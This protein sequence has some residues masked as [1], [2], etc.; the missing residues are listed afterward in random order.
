MFG[1]APRQ[2]ARANYSGP[3]SSPPSRSRARRGLPR[4]SYCS[5]TCQELGV[6]RA[7]ESPLPVAAS[8]RPSFPPRRSGGSGG[9]RR[10]RWEE[11]GCG[12]CGRR[13]RCSAGSRAPRRPQGDPAWPRGREAKPGK[14][15]CTWRRTRSRAAVPGRPRGLRLPRSPLLLLPPLPSGVCCGAAPSPPGESGEG[16]ARARPT[17]LQL[18]PGLS[19]EERPPRPNCHLAVPPGHPGRIQDADT[20]TLAFARP[21]GLP[22]SPA[23]SSRPQL[24]LWICSAR[25]VTSGYSC[26]LRPPRCP[27]VFSV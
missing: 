27:F 8:P 4:P 25:V 22:L 24:G 15:S 11:T 7:T 12:D 9:E 17:A 3:G 19:L 10:R 18:P 26:R 5:D 16:L 6:S 1:C 20:S 21:A 14:S 2:A 13:G 23:R